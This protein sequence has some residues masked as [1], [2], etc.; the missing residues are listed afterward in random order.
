MR[1]QKFTNDALN[2][3]GNGTNDFG[4]FQINSIHGYTHEQL[5]DYK[6]NTDI[7]YKLFTRVQIVLGHGLVAMWSGMKVFGN[8]MRNE[9]GQFIKGITPPNKG[10]KVGQIMV[11][12]RKGTF[13]FLNQ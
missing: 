7:A 8:N 10:K 2:W 11:V 4:L 6:F 12:S 1:K 9:K 3:N 5:Q 13:H